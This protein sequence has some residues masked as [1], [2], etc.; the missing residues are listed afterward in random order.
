MRGAGI[1]DVR[2]VGGAVEK[3]LLGEQVGGGVWGVGHALL[4]LGLPA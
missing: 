4:S 3:E 1:L 2:R